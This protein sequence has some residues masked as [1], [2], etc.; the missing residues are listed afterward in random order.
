[1]NVAEHFDALF[2]SRPWGR[3]P[4][5]D[6]I[7]AVSTRFPLADRAPRT[8]LEIGCGPGA[9]LG[10]LL[11]NNFAVA[12]LDVS[13]EAIAQ[14]EQRYATH[15]QRD[16]LWLTTQTDFRWLPTEGFARVLC[17]GIGRETVDLIL[18]VCCFQESA[19]TEADGTALFAKCKHLL[20]EGGLLFSKYLAPDSDLPNG[21]LCSYRPTY[22]DLTGMLDGFAEVEIDVVTETRGNGSTFYKHWVICARR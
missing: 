3:Y 9:N 5:M 14:A 10:F 7:K 8:A 6:L 12:A 15:P 19:A 17:H 4:D 21:S 2:K 1:M 22:P 16:G 18:D 13:K 11:E 20:R